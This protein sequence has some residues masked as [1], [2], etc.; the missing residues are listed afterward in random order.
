M[1]LMVI[2]NLTQQNSPYC[3][4]FTRTMLLPLYDSPTDITD[5][6]PR[7]YQSL[8]TS[9]LKG[10]DISSGRNDTQAKSALVAFLP[11]VHQSLIESQC[12]ELLPY[13]AHLWRED[14]GRYLTLFS[15]LERDTTP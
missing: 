11:P 12:P 9:T 14:V 15:L 3:R 6:P 4:G 5:N 1:T 13:F 7:Q 8:S 2:G 10:R